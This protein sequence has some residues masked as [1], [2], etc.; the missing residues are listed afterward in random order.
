MVELQEQMREHGMYPKCFDVKTAQL[1]LFGMLLM[2]LY[3]GV[4]DGKPL[5]HDGKWGMATLEV[6]LAIIDS[7]KQRK[8]IQ[9]SRQVP[10]ED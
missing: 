8:E 3:G 4:V 10:I 1:M 5:F 9:M 7:A 6:C 2:D